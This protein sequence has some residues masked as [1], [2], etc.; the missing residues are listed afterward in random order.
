MSRFCR[1]DIETLFF[2]HKQ[3]LLVVFFFHR[4][5]VV[6]FAGDTVLTHYGWEAALK[7]K[8]AQSEKYWD[9]GTHNISSVFSD[10]LSL[11]LR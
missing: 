3:D 1:F 11:L 7:G 8:K 5:A 2:F 9:D 6:Q 10:S 4:Y